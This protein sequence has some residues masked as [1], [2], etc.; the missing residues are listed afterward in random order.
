VAKA[1]LVLVGDRVPQ[2]LMMVMMMVVVVVVVVVVVGGG[3]RNIN[4]KQE[5]SK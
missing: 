4:I 1:L 3:R 2:E 5:P